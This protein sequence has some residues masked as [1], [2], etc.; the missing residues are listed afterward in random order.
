M[1]PLLLAVMNKQAVARGDKQAKA[2]TGAPTRAEATE[3]R[4]KLFTGSEC[5]VRKQKNG[6]V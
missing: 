6:Q 1:N 4:S 2:S 5:L 3:E